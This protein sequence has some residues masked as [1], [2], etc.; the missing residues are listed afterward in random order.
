MSICEPEHNKMGT[1]LVIPFYGDSPWLVEYLKN[2]YEVM[3]IKAKDYED[4]KIDNI[5]PDCVIIDCAT[6][7]EEASQLAQNIRKNAQ[8]APFL[9]CLFIE[10][11]PHEMKN[12]YHL[13]SPFDSGFTVPASYSEVDQRI[14]AS[15]EK[16]KRK[17]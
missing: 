8:D 14:Q 6:R 16:R 11:W 2:N 17:E 15:L 3:V 13:L 4:G 12:V 7:I 5:R 1:I 9:V 10:R